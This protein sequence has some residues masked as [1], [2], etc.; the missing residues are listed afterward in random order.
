MCVVGEAVP[1]PAHLGYPIVESIAR[2]LEANFD[3]FPM[4]FRFNH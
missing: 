1:S 3:W 4:G 2:D